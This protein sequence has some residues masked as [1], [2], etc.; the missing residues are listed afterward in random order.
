M[1]KTDV[2]QALDILR[3]HYERWKAPAKTLAGHHRNDPFRV[4]VCALLSTRTR[5]E[6]TSRV[7]RRLFERIKK[8]EDVVNL[9]LN[10]LR[11]LIYP[12]GFY[13]SKAKQLKALSALLVE[14]FGGKVPDSLEDLLSLPGV[15]RKVAN[16][17]LSEGYGIPA[18]CVD[19]H[20]H[21]I[22]NRWCLV[23]TET[24]LQTEKALM[25]LIP[26]EYWSLL[27]RLLVAFGQRICTPLKPKCHACPIERLCG[28]CG[29]SSAVP[30]SRNPRV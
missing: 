11:E 23:K 26:E 7:C 29:V 22:V 6:T 24:P 28:K 2:P 20:V 4:L 27:N 5:D 14:R 1:R 10:E 18:I 19:T 21:R 25:E 12:V 8:P 9:P 17:V 30:L 13:R 15:G 3:E 16:L